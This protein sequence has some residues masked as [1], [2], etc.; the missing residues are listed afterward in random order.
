M[1]CNNC[2]AEL[3]DNAKF[4]TSCGSKVE[5][6]GPQAGP[7]HCPNCGSQLAGDASFCTNCG[8]RLG[9]PARQRAPRNN[10]IRPR[11]NQEDVKKLG[12]AIGGV[13][14]CLLLLI[15]VIIPLFKTGLSEKK[16]TKMVESTINSIMDFDFEKA[17]KN[18]A[19]VTDDDY[20]DLVDGVT[21]MQ[22]EMGALLGNKTLKDFMDIKVTPMAFTCNKSTGTAQGTYSVNFSLN[23]KGIKNPT[24]NGLLNMALA[25]GGPQT[26]EV[27]FVKVGRKWK[28]SELSD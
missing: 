9:G 4:C 11:K 21:S 24:I 13:V 23:K 8:Q 27:E 28:I 12:L 10:Y 26:L 6:V 25:S 5:N 17:S 1:R 2:G 7:K 22:K 14:L 16:A 3:Q 15:F 19:N 20:R 18:F